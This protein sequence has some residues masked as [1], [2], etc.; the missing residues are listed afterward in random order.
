[1]VVK[2]SEKLLF[3]VLCALVFGWVYEGR[4]SMRKAKATI[5]A[6]YIP[7]K[8]TGWITVKFNVKKSPA[9]P[10]IKKGEGGI[11]K[12]VV[13]ENGVVSTSSALYEGKH[14]TKYYRYGKK[15]VTLFHEGAFGIKPV[16]APQETNVWINGGMYNESR[17][18]FYVFQ[19]PVPPSVQ[20]PM[21]GPEHSH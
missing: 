6:Y 18:Q 20:P 9:V 3:V 16:D 19:K 10:F 15:G 5:V 17:L 12:I 11:Y 1:M 7:E 13:P 14:L 8:Y 21:P 2:Y 4:V